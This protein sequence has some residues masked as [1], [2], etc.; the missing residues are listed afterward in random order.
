MLFALEFGRRRCE[1]RKGGGMGSIQ[2][3]GGMEG[4]K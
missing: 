1:R 2:S 3:C 4:V